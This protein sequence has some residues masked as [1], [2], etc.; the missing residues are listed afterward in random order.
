MRKAVSA[1]YVN[2]GP[3]ERV[4]GSLI[5]SIRLFALYVTN[6]VSA[7]RSVVV[8][9]RPLLSNTIFVESGYDRVYVEPLKYID[10]KSPA[11][12][13]HVTPLVIAH[14]KYTPEP[15]PSTTRTVLSL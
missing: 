13:A 9:S 15:S 7:Q 8:I 10:V 11:G 2:L 1:R 5:C 12:P 4:I 14:P 3:T 6:V